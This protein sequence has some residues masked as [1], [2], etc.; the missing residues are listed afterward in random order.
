MTNT[1]ATLSK[2]GSEKCTGCGVCML[3]CPVW[4]QTRDIML[5]A[6][7]RT[8]TLQNGGGPQDMRD[9]L[10]A[11]VLCG[12]CGPVC[13]AGV[14]TVGLTTELRM[15]LAEKTGPA[16]DSAPGGQSSP[17]VKACGTVFFPGSAM[18]KDNSLLGHALRLLEQEA[19]FYEDAEISAMAEKMEAGIWPDPG[20]LKDFV[21][22]MAGVTEIV[23][24]DGFL[25]RHLR[26][27][28]PEVRV[29]GFGE[30]LLRRPDIKKAL[31][32]TDLY[33]I[34]ARGYHADH[35]RL[36]NFYDRLR[37]E[38]GCR[39]NTS[40]QRTA[41]PTGATSRQ[42]PGP[43]RVDA[44]EQARWIL[45]KRKTERVVAE[46]VEDMKIFKKIPGIEV[47]HVAEL[48]SLA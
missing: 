9:S 44:R 40:L 24:A 15:D 36:V 21:R 19:G 35:S 33:M 38:T 31:K 5:T 42:N 41:I 43:V 34:E 37:L 45:D 8:R 29:T 1:S 25:H 20:S 4:R 7:G 46:A 30:T 2:Y 3:T 6:C 18:R 12:S 10:A 26:Q 22:S 13:P 28:L 47:I 48:L 14:D 23:A 27:W 32:A 39:L 11:C 16:P 17:G